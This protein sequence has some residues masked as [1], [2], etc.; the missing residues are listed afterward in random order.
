MDYRPGRTVSAKGTPRFGRFLRDHSFAKH[1]CRSRDSFKRN[2]QYCAGQKSLR[3]L[4]LM[5]SCAF[6]Q[7]HHSNGIIYKYTLTVTRIHATFTHGLAVLRAGQSPLQCPRPPFCF[8][9][10]EY[11]SLLYVSFPRCEGESFFANPC[12]CHTS[13]KRTYNSFACHTSKNTGFKALCLPHIQKMA[14]VGVFCS[15]ANTNQ[16]GILILMGAVSKDPCVPEFAYDVR[17][18]KMPAK[19]CR[20]RRNKIPHRITTTMAS[21]RPRV[22]MSR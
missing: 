4:S 14:G 1:L 10:G 12:I 3:S 21:G 2:M 22:S 6:R 20:W 17:C 8:P 5:E 9:S 15:P 16:E 19:C 11:S 7:I 18:T 13:E